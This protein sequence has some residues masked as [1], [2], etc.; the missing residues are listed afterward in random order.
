[1]PRQ[2]TSLP[3]IDSVSECF[4]RAGKARNLETGDDDTAAAIAATTKT[5]G[6]TN[7]RASY[8]LPIDEEV[9]PIEQHVKDKLASGENLESV[10]SAIFAQADTA[11]L[12]CL[13]LTAL[14]ESLRSSAVTCCGSE[15][16]LTIQK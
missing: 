1:M 10:A 2:V 8:I 15:A 3:I 6:V 4:N 14:L 13:A 9:I 11:K 16:H 12:N 5:R 7:Y